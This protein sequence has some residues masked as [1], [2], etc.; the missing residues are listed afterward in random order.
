MKRIP[1]KVNVFGAEYKVEVKPH[2]IAPDEIEVWGLFLPDEMKI[3]L[4]E[5]PNTNFMIKNLYHE[6]GH[7][8]IDRIG[9]SQT[10]LDADH[11]E[12]ICH[13]F[14]RYICEKFIFKD[15]R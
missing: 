14:S 6:I 13:A 15:K 9:L 11:E 3:I 10:S 12:A 5:H 4:G 8:I 1:K 7:A 2:P